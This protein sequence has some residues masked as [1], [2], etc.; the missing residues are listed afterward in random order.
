MSHRYPRLIENRARTT[1]LNS[2]HGIRLKGTVASIARRALP[3]LSMNTL[4]FLGAEVQGRSYG[5]GILKMEPREAA[6]LPVTSPAVL[7]AA[8]SRLQGR[9]RTLELELRRGAWEGVVAEVDRAVLVDT[10][11]MEG[12]AMRKLAQATETLRSR[13]LGT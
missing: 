10:L 6:A 2:M 11:G 5:G 1:F 13:R 7:S 9:S 12:N 3:L 4:T 8:W